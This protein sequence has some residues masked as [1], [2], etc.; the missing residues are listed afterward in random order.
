MKLGI[1]LAVVIAVV[2]L[3]GSALIIPLLPRDGDPREAGRRWGP[4]VFPAMLVGFG[5]GYW[6]EKRRNS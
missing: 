1:I 3:L 5:I 6:I 2:W 4:T